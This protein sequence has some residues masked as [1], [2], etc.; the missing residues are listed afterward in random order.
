[1]RTSACIA[2]AEPAP[3][4]G[5]AT[6]SIPLERTSVS[7]VSGMALSRLLISC[8]KASIFF[9]FVSFNVTSFRSSSICRGK[10]D[11]QRQL[12]H[13]TTATTIHNCSYPLPC[14]PAPTTSL[15]KRA[16]GELGNT[17]APLHEPCLEPGVQSAPRQKNKAA[18][19]I[20]SEVLEGNQLHPHQLL[21]EVQPQKTLM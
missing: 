17:P 2:T 7:G 15:V 19:A 18:P 21:Y 10:G 14:P 20:S 13:C 3:Y 4:R 16:A 12:Q 8:R 5:L 9:F 1:M 6:S 11:H